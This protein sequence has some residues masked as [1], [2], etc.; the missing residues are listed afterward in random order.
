MAKKVLYPSAPGPVTVIECSPYV[1]DVSGLA[2][3][4]TALMMKP[5][6]GAQWSLRIWYQISVRS[7][8]LFSPSRTSMTGLTVTA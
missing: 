2:V 1:S 8:S 3:S 5:S 4:E 6:S 7:Q